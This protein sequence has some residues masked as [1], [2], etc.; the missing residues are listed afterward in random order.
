MFTDRTT[1]YIK[2]GNGGN[3]SVSFRTEIHE[4][5][6]GPDGGDG[7]KG[8]DIIFISDIGIRSLR[9]FNFKRHFKAENG[10]N[11]KSKNRTGKTAENLVIKVPVGTVLIDS[12]NDEVIAD[13]TKDKEEK[14]ILIGGKG[15]KGNTQYKNSKRRSPNFAEAGSLG[16]E[17]NLILELKQISDIGLVGLPNA[18]KSTLLNA[19]T[20]AKS[21][22][23]SYEFT[24]I[25][26]H[27]GVFTIK[28]RRIVLA[29]IPGLIK[30]AAS[31]KGLGIRF[32]KHIERTKMI[33]HLIDIS[34]PDVDKMIENFE[35]INEE[36][37][38]Y[39]RNLEKK[40]MIVLGTK[41]DMKSTEGKELENH[42]KSKGLEYIE[43]SS[44]SPDDV[45]KIKAVIY[46]NLGKVKEDYYMASDI[47]Y[48]AKPIEEDI[49]YTEINIEK[50][51]NKLKI[52]G[53]KLYKIFSSTNFNDIS[54]ARYFF[55]YLEEEGVIEK[56]V[57]MGLK[58]GDDLLVFDSV[59]EF[60]I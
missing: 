37:A 46:E 52:T 26:P 30:G 24:T 11:G 41:S 21:K 35:L 32:L 56:L 58:N 2:S 51:N 14:L 33:L 17:M 44:F 43:V 48:E 50:V 4:P 45:E 60:N 15:G 55:K 28:G 47:L 23:G 27:L 6:G 10:E 1:I 12:S 40:K 25:D 16:K 9:D 57:A 22:V 34:N 54:S 7:G 53:K 39:K 8:G 29:D 42:I 5:K 49:N 36:L 38:N 59:L 20:N 18:G 19:L 3:G 31:G 13:F